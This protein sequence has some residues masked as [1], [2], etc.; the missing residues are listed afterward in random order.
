YVPLR[1]FLS[2][3]LFGGRDLVIFY[4]RGGGITFAQREMQSDFSKAVSGYDSFHGTSFA[5]SLPRNADG[6]L[7]LLESY[8]RLRLH[9]GKRIALVIDYA[10]TIA[11]AGGISFM[12]TEDRNSLVILKR[13]SHDTLFL[14]SDITICLIAE[15][16]AELNESLVQS[17]YAG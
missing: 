10:E 1:R 14:Y 3:A 6:V 2:E 17:P 12:S 15:N 7:S 16:L 4:D 9:E 11:P 5:H 8:I 13:W